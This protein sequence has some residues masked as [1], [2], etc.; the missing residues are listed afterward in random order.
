MTPV[1]DLREKAKAFLDEHSIEVAISTGANAGWPHAL[2]PTPTMR[3]VPNEPIADLMAAFAAARVEAA[4]RERPRSELL[5]KL[6]AAAEAIDWKEECCGNGRQVGEFEQECCGCPN[7]TAV[8][9]QE[10]VADLLRC[11]EDAEADLSRVRAELQTAREEL[12]ALLP[13]AKQACMGAHHG[14]KFDPFETCKHPDCAVVR[15]LTAPKA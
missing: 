7:F 2:V 3:R 9:H 5:A 12:T 6:H 13:L 10:F 4:L 1:P 8:V 14:H 11:S 15:S